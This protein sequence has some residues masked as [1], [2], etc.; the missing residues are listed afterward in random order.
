[1]ITPIKRVILFTCFLWVLLMKTCWGSGRGWV[2]IEV[3][4]HFV[5]KWYKPNSQDLKPKQQ[6]KTIHLTGKSRGGT[7]RRHQVVKHSCLWIC[8]LR[9][10]LWFP[11]SL[12][13]KAGVLPAEEYL[14]NVSPIFQCL[15]TIFHTKLLIVSYVLIPVK[16][17]RHLCYR[18]SAQPN[19]LCQ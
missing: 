10:P 18:P 13:L 6:N 14:I 7:Y 1:M 3:N 4:S 12:L 19:Y 15:Y 2:F 8:Q 17:R 16:A 5:Y 11:H 9:F